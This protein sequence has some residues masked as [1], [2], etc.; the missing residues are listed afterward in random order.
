MPIDQRLT[1]AFRLQPLLLQ[2][3]LQL[4][5]LEQVVNYF[6]DRLHRVLRRQDRGL[7]RG[8][9]SEL[10]SR[11][12]V[13]VIKLSFFVADGSKNHRHLRKID[14]PQLIVHVF[15]TVERGILYAVA[16]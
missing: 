12:S 2:Q 1:V 9:K 8:C 11:P 3:V 16:A 7:R 6:R 15:T 10:T 14:C 4:A 13:D 5:V